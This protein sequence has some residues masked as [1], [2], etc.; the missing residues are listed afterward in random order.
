MLEWI[1]YYT[2]MWCR[3]MACNR[4]SS[5]WVKRCWHILSGASCAVHQFDW[6]EKI[7]HSIIACDSIELDFFLLTSPVL[8]WNSAVMS[9]RSRH[10]WQ[11]RGTFFQSR[12]H[13]SDTEGHENLFFATHI[14][15]RIVYQFSVFNLME[16][17]LL[18]DP[19]T[20]TC[21]NWISSSRWPALAESAAKRRKSLWIKHRQKLMG[22]IRIFRF[23]VE[24]KT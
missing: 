22:F 16:A 17:H 24:S 9:F 6:N 15:Y 2:R 10:K 23:L 12:R 11:T 13:E 7:K 8:H 18:V 14:E 20:S 3:S 4:I 5:N 21:H 1:N 19:E